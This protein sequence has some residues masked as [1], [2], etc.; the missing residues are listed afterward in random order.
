MPIAQH[1]PAQAARRLIA[2]CGLPVDDIADRELKSFFGCGSADEPAGVVGVEMYGDVALL[3]SLAVAEAARGQGCR[4]QLVEAA[5]TYA[6][7]SGARAIYLL[8]P[9]ARDYF[10]H[11][12]YMT[13]DRSQAPEALRGSSQLAGAGCSGATL[14]AKQLAV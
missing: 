5:E 3:R 4:R 6:Q 9:T 12:G 1:P 2:A 14:M 13:I 8:T 10:A 11:L 7:C